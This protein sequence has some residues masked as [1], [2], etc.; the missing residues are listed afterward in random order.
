ML[1]TIAL[2][3]C[4]QLLFYK[5]LK[6]YIYIILYI[7]TFYKINIDNRNYESWNIFNANTLELIILEEFNPTQH[8]LFTNDIR[9]KVLLEPVILLEDIYIILYTI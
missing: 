7:M 2:H 3:I 9:S 1:N 5:I 4:R 6:G 8:K